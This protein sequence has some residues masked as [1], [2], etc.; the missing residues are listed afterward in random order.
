M[1]TPNMYRDATVKEIKNNSCSFDGPC[2]HK[3][4]YRWRGG[5][6]FC[7]THFL[8]EMKD[9]I[10]SD[11]SDSSDSDDSD[12][13]DSDDSDSSDSDDSDSDSSDSDDSDSDSS[14]SDDS[15]SEK[16]EDTVKTTNKVVS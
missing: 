8:E 11:D 16:N 13:S 1:T 7:K 4:K 12:S 15:D 10:T 6:F 3:I 9:S 2:D 5:Y 14:D